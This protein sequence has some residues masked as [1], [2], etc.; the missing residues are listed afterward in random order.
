MSVREQSIIE[1]KR[2]LIRSARSH[3]AGLLFTIWTDPRVM[4]HVGY[5]L[6]LRISQREIV[7][8]MAE[9]DFTRP[10]WR[11]LIIEVK[12]SH[13]SI[14]ECK[15][16]LPDKEGISRTDVKLLPE[17][18][19]HKYGLEVKQA[20]V[21]YLFEHTAC[22]AVEGTPNVNNIASIKMQ[23]AVGAVRISGDTFYFPES[24]SAYTTPVHH[25]VYHVYRAAWEKRQE[26]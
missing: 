20:L 2:L 16:V 23:E 18:W 24:M 6:G 26:A 25:S 8:N 22:L 13:L 5:P 14:G 17:Q 15:M 3:D 10:F 7:E 21:D 9:Q 1:T 11:Y 19:G 12:E 4:T